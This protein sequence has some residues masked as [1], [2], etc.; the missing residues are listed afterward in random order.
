MPG[1]GAET[2]RREGMRDVGLWLVDVLAEDFGDRPHSADA[3]APAGPGA[4]TGER[5]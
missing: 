3:E 5:R 1:D 4:I 2:A